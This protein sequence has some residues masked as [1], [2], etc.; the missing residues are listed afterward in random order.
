MTALKINENENTH[1]RAHYEGVVR[2]TMRII[3]RRKLLVAAILVEALV[4]ASIALVLVGPRYT[5]EAIIQLSFSREES[6]SSAKS[7]PIVSMEAAAIV[8]GAARVIR[9][10]AT[11]SAVVARLGLDKD[12]TFTRQSFSWRVLSSVRSALGMEQALP[13]RD[14]D[15]AVNTLMQRVAVTNEPRS[16]LISIAVTASDPA[17]AAGL[18]NAVAFEYLRAQML[19]RLTE[20]YATVE[21]EV[22]ELSTVYGIHHPNPRYL[23]ARARL[24]RLQARLSALRQEGPD[25]DVTN[26]VSSQRG[27]LLPAETV[28]VPS[29]PNIVL[30]LALTAGAALVLGAWLAVLLG[31][32]LAGWNRAG[33]DAVRG[34]EAVLRAMGSNAESSPLASVTARGLADGPMGRNGKIVGRTLSSKAET[35]ETLNARTRG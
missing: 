17:R 31:R 11:A 33:Y 1:L 34:D 16:Y 5:G 35:E 3:W 7:Q 28:M 25:E 8:D 19:Q 9:S 24:E 27:Q 23:D 26:L 21:S 4:L 20:T 12:P 6:A 30:I 22:A 10:R 18:A 13:P 29:G 32:N 15:L 2:D 14:H